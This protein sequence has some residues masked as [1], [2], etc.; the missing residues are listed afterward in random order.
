MVVCPLHSHLAAVA[1][2][3]ASAAPAKRLVYVM[4]DAAAL[5]LVLSDL[6]ADLRS[7]NLLAASVSAGRSRSRSHRLMKPM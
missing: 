6:V 3:F 1:C 4:T 2:G 7:R 5:P